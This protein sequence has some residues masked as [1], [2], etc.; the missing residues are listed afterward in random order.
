MNKA[1][2]KALKD[3]V[4]QKG[5]LASLLPPLTIVVPIMMVA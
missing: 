2:R 3:D 1:K 4:I 5:L